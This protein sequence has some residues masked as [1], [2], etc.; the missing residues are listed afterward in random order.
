MTVHQLSKQSTWCADSTCRLHKEMFHKL[1]FSATNDWTWQSSGI[2]SW[3][4]FITSRYFNAS[5]AYTRD[6][7]SGIHFQ[8]LDLTLSRSGLPQPTRRSWPG[9]RCQTNP[10]PQSL[11]AHFK[12]G[13]DQRG[14]GCVWNHW[15]AGKGIS[16]ESEN[17][18]P[19]NR[20]N[21]E[22]LRPFSDPQ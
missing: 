11:L 4:P 17:Q 8:E 16:T 22:L 1:P 7:N 18:P 14:S 5:L 10:C 20:E 19:P 3:A 2:S 6:L 15:P 12:A 13:C 21:T 9:S